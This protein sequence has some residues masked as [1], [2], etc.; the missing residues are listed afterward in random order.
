MKIIH[1]SSHYN[2]RT[3]LRRLSPLV[4][5]QKLAC[6]FAIVLCGLLTSCS[7]KPTNVTKAD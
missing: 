4:L 7:S 5:V 2:N 6:V 3:K 1:N